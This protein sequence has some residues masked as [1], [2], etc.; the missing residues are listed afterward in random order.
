MR[1]RIAII[2]SILA[3]VILIVY[4]IYF[5]TIG[6]VLMP[7]NETVETLSIY[8]KTTV[9]AVTDSG[10]VY[11]K[12]Y[13]TK[14]SNYGV[15]RIRQYNNSKPNAF[16]RIYD[17][18]D[19]V[20]VNIGE[21]GG[22]IITSESDVFVF[23]NGNENFRIPTY[24]C[25]GYSKAYLAGDDVYLLS[26]DGMFGFV[27]I[28]QPDDFIVLG[29]DVVDFNIAYSD[30]L[31]PFSVY[32]ALTSDNRLYVSEFGKALEDCEQYFDDIIDFN[33]ISFCADLV[34]DDR[35]KKYIEI[36]FID[37]DHHAYWYEGDLDES[38]SKI[39]DKSNYT[40]AGSNIQS[41][42]AYPRGIAMLDSKGDASIYGH[43][44]NYF[45]L[46]G[47]LTGEVLFHDV[48]SLYSGESNLI[49][50][51]RNG[52]IEYFG[53][54]FN[55]QTTKYIDDSFLNNNNSNE[56]TGNKSTEDENNSTE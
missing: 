35:V 37:S 42:V 14:D 8:G 39:T 27:N 31:Y 54:D 22:C 11:V 48:K 20:S 29:S 15:D 23:V 19:A 25:S 10:N 49:V 56:G 36:S 38:L 50:Q 16:A 45:G 26:G 2:T 17:K 4:F 5:D 53:Y 21:S 32:F 9:A 30:S 52:D 7:D 51:Y 1:K 3:A 46:E 41:A 6:V 28:D 40:L 44:F 18:M 34:E 12:W 47:F 55:K 33:T 24:L 43:D 13:A